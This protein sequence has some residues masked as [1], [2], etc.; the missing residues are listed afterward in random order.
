MESFERSGLRFGVIDSGPPDG[1]VAVLFHGFPQ[2]P[3]TYRL[4]TRALNAAGVRTLVPEQRGYVASARPARR[5]DYRTVELVDDA[6]ALLDAAEVQRAHLVGHDWGAA[7][8]WGMAAWHP[9]RTASVTSLSTPHPAALLKSFL[10]S[11]QA[12]TSWYMAFLQLPVLPELLSRRGLVRTLTRSGLPDVWVQDYLA[13][14][15]EPGRLTGAINWYR[16][17]P[18]SA[19]PALGP[20]EVPTTYIWGRH[21]F[22]LNR[23]TAELVGNYV[24][25]PYRF[26]DLDASHWLPETE[27]EI[28]ADEILFRMGR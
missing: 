16:G 4:V 3:S 8:V 23:T 7:P 10:T 6:L 21:D 24:V 5:R 1:P 9:D 20:I 26:V 18:F 22:A 28:V 14:M 15:A 11:T 25:G 13:A 12:L 17:L 2:Q 27:P 19:R